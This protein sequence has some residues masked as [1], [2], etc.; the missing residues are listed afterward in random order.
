MKCPHCSNLLRRAKYGKTVIDL[1]PNCKGIWFD[2]GELLD[3]ARRLAASEDV[4]AQ[5]TELFKH[6]EVSSLYDIEEK[7]RLCPRC[8]K[9]LRKF[10]YACDSNVILDKCPDCDGIWADGGEVRQIAAY[11]KDDPQATAVGKAI[12]QLSHTEEIDS[13]GPGFLFL[14]RVIMPLSDDTPRERVPV[15]TISIIACCALLFIAQLIFNPYFL[16]EAFD[17]VPEDIFAIDLL[18]SMFS[19]GGFLAFLWNMLF[20]WLFGDNVEDRFSHLGYLVFFLCCALFATVLYSFFD[21]NL[22]LSAIG[23]SGAVSG[24]MGAY[25]IFYP[26]ANI[27]IFVVYN[28]MEVPTVVCLGLWFL[29]QI[30]SPFLFKTATAV[31]SLCFAHV[32]GFILGMAVAAVK[33]GLISTGR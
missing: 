15:V 31:N 12:A 4:P 19:Q 6:R 24:I 10:N 23:V 5:K 25:F 13:V 18:A 7:E 30:I 1:C 32:G 29:F 33:K 27:R 9:E 20:L 14:P 8:S 22:S 2:S 21:S 11:L 3:V 28:T 26:T 16:A 17:S